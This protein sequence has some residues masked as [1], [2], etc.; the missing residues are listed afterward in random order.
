M[1]FG[2]HS[3]C[4]NTWRYWEGGLLGKEQKLCILPL[5][6]CAVHLFHLAILELYFF[7]IN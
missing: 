3:G 7:V 2:D 4:L 1:G 5:L 6:T